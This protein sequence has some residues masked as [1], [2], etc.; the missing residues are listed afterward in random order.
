M[1]PAAMPRIWIARTVAK[2]GRAVFAEACREDLEGIVAKW[3]PSPYALLNGRSPW[4]KI[5]N[6]RYSQAVG[7]HEWFETRG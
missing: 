4:V 5:K 7:R 3:M 1:I 6:P 2:Q